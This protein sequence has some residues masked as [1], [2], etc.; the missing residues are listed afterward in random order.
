M[1]YVELENNIVKA[2]YSKD[3]HVNI[4]KECIEISDELWQELLKLGQARLK[5]NKTEDLVIE[6]FEQYIK[7]LTLD[8]KIELLRNKRSTILKAF[9]IYK[10]NVQY[11]IEIESEKE[12]E[13]ILNWYQELL[14][15][16]ENAFDNIPEKIKRYL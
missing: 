12:R 14:D 4:P 2:F 16:K 1:K 5:N 3:I 7:S 9:D 6:D 11:R 13:I 8:E 10:T 15:L